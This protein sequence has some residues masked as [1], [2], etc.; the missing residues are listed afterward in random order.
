MK[1]KIDPEFKSIIPPLSDEERNRLRE[2]LISEG[3]RDPLVVW[4]EKGVLLDGHNRLE[5]CDECEISYAVKEISLTDRT[6]AKVWIL[7]NQMG[8]RNLS[9]TQRSMLAARLA[10]LTEGRP[11]KTPENSG[12]SQETAGNLFNVSTDLVGF[13]KKVLD[14]GSDALIKACEKD[15]IAVSAAAEI[16]T[17]PKA[18]QADV[19]AKGKS[20][21]KAAVKE[22]K[23]KKA[24]ARKVKRAKQKAA[25]VA[26]NHPLKGKSFRL[27]C[28][29]ILEA[30]AEIKDES[31]DAIITDPP[32]PEE[33]IPCYGV[34]A[35]VAARVLRPG[36]FVLAMAGQ[37][38][39]PEIMVM[40]TANV[41]LRYQWTLGYFTPGESTQ[42]FGRKV[43]SNWKP[44]VW[45]VKGKNDW[46]HVEDT[47]RS[48]ANDKRFHEWGQS[49]G[50]MAQLI[51]RFTVEK[52][53][54]LDPF[55]GG[56]STAVAALS[57]GRLF[58]GIDIDKACIQETAERIGEIV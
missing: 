22:I 15:E 43:K 58:V 44:I 6:T 1:I 19:L 18:D 57:L 24:K 38:H 5:I 34:L 54:V 20:G 16:A 3:C 30:S 25:A 7:R 36:G 13:A 47:V 50:G 11:L 23:K 2:N 21:L 52:S 8:R 41:A 48:D 42:V 56:G 33:F 14:E 49:V 28:G 53:L 40:L 45:L 35:D 29:D 4:K 32:Y 39:L 10:D 17:L 9:G 31:V 26:K 12:V 27:I 55:V 37:S 46:E 51:E